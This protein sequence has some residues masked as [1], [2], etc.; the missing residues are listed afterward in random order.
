[1]L[2]VNVSKIFWK[3]GVPLATTAISMRRRPLDSA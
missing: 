3:F 2:A 1:M